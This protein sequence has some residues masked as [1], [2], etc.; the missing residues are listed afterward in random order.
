[1]TRVPIL[2]SIIRI[3]YN[4]HKNGCMGYVKSEYENLP[5]IGEAWIAA[6]EFNGPVD[7][8]LVKLK[9]RENVKTAE[10]ERN[11]DVDARGRRSL[12]RDDTARDRKDREHQTR[13]L[14]WL[15][16][17]DIAYRAAHERAM[18][19]FTNAGHAIDRAIEAGERASEKL[20][21]QI[22]DY[23]AATPRLKD[24]RYVMI[25]EAGNYW[26][27]HR[28]PVSA[29]DAAE[30][31]GQPKRAFKPYDEMRERKDGIDRDLAELRGLDV[32]VG[33]MKNEATDEKTPAS[34]ER[35]DDMTKRADQITKD[36]EK[37]T[38]SF[39]ASSPL[40]NAAQDTV[41]DKVSITSA[42]AVPRI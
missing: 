12:A 33:G 38:R 35:L 2:T 40:Y 32:E 9:H 13:S 7:P 1:M 30:V 4:I 16:A 20:R 29:E 27:Q 26:D 15:L 6:K 39:E 31:E 37:M 28:K 17:N 25:D 34:R 5:D 18:L 41:E 36:A 22:D 24:G 19:S 11:Q 23:L 21:Q 10:E 14:T 3:R 42:I 8:A